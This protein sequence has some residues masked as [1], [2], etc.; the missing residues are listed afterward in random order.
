M[1]LTH[2]AAILVRFSS[3]TQLAFPKQDGHSANKARVRWLRVDEYRSIVT[4][5]V[6]PRCES[7][8]ERE[9]RHFLTGTEGHVGELLPGGGVVGE[10]A[11]GVELVTLRP[12]VGQPL[13]DGGR[14]AHLVAHRDGVARHTLDGQTN[15]QTNKQTNTRYCLR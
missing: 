2:L 3:P 12:R 13:V 1:G 4:L 15:T 6:F 11:V 7:E 14:D 10:V 9:R 5:K 8:G